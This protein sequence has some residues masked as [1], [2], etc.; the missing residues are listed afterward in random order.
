MVSERRHIED[1]DDD[2]YEPLEAEAVDSVEEA[3]EE[4]DEL[5]DVTADLPLDE[6]VESA[7]PDEVEIV[8]LSGEDLEEPVA[9]TPET[10][11]EP[12][13]NADSP[14]VRAPDEWQPETQDHV[15]GDLDSEGDWPDE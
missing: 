12:P 9:I 4:A 3:S 1:E 11:L 7:S 10:E 8:A 15:P 6:R 5:D 13:E 2:A 14:I